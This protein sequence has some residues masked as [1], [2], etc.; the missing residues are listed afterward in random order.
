MLDPA[1]SG[2]A[3]GVLLGARVVLAPVLVAASVAAALLARGHGRAA[4]LMHVFFDLLAKE[5]GAHAE[6][7][8]AAYEVALR[9]S[10][11]FGL[12]KEG[13]A[14]VRRLWRQ[15]LMAAELPRLSAAYASVP[16]QQKGFYLQALT[17]VLRGTPRDAVALELPRVLPLLVQALAC[18][19]KGTKC[20][21][22]ALMLSFISGPSAADTAKMLEGQVS[23]LVPSL[24]GLTKYKAALKVRCLAVECLTH[25]ATLL[26]FHKVF[27]FRVQV[28]R[29]LGVSIADHK[30]CVRLRAANC[31]NVWYMLTS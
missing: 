9:P 13:H 5:G 11:A 10:A 19:G 2:G 25:L 31:R 20:A 29:E 26:P 14:G 7:G 12:S 1:G 28:T 3:G 16:P 15:R 22:L 18:D 21:A 6:A 17:Y 24:L 4:E 30:R 27:P 23:T 8:A